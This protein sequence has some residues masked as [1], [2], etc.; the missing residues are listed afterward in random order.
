M[1]QG[2]DQATDTYVELW[3]PAYFLIAGSVPFVFGGRYVAETI[4]TLNLYLVFVL[5]WDLFCGPTREAN[6]GHSFFIGGAAYFTGWL[7]VAQG[8]PV[9]ASALA[10]LAAAGALGAGIGWVAD[11]FRGPSFALATM[12]VQLILFQAVFLFPSVF[13]AEEGIVGL[14]PVARS[15]VGRHV[16]VLSAAAAVAG[17][18]WMLHRSRA[19]LVLIAIGEDE[20]LAKSSGVRSHRLK[21]A[22]FA[23]SAGLGGLGGVLYAHTQGQVNSE[24]VGSALSVHIVLLGLLGGARTGPAA[25]VVLFLLL[26]RL[27][28]EVVPMQAVVY[29]LLLL[30]AVIMFP[31]GIVPRAVVEE[32]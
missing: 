26:Q 25:A 10:A 29:T 7:H 17:I 12:A 9:W 2:T 5:S 31:R 30:G 13:G 32:P 28:A 19:G 21:I 23:L 8:L 22:V 18:R 15:W 3:L 14:D 27:L 1:R 6:F 4:L 20:V 24:I 11:R 16:V